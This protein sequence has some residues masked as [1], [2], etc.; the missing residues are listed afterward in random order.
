MGADKREDSCW[1][2]RNFNDILGGIFSPWNHQIWEQ[3]AQRDYGFSIF[4]NI[5]T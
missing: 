1:D 2:V 3:A 4:G 5:Q